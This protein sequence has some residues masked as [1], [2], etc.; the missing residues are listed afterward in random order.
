[1]FQHQRSHRS[2]WDVRRVRFTETSKLSAA[3][4]KRPR[5]ST[6]AGPAPISTSDTGHS[7]TNRRAASVN[8]SGGFSFGFQTIKLISGLIVVAFSYKLTWWLSFKRSTWSHLVK[9]PAEEE[10]PRSYISALKIL[11]LNI[12]S[13]CSCELVTCILVSN[14]SRDVQHLPAQRDAADPKQQAFPPSTPDAEKH[15]S[16]FSN[17]MFCPFSFPG[18]FENEGLLW[19]MIPPGEQ[20]PLGDRVQTLDGVSLQSVG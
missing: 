7:V 13:S 2:V 9:V 5:P 3:G 19:V 4:Y 17:L 18:L 12:F 20:S 6:T 11:M 1:M 15:L 10:K 16:H 14:L 8:L